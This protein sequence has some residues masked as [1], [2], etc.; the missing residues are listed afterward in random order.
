MFDTATIATIVAGAAPLLFA[1]MGETISEKAGV[2]N[3]SVDGSMMLAALAGFVAA[4]ETGSVWLGFPA[5]AAVGMLVALVVAF[6][7]IKLSLNQVAVGFVL[8]ALCTQLSRFLGSS[9]VGRLPEAVPA[10]DV[11]LLESIPFFGRVLFQQNLMVYLSILT[12]IATY[13]YMYRTRKGLELQGIGERPEAAHAR[14]IPVNR[15]R[16][17]YTALG[18]AL[19]GI[20]GAAFTLDVKLG[21][22]DRPTL[23]F[24]WIVLAIVIFGGWHPIRVAIGVLLFGALQA[25]ALN[26]IPEFPSL[27][28]VLPSIPFPLM[29]LALVIVNWKALLRW[30]DRY[31][32]LR[33]I[34][35]S[36]PPT[37]IG[38]RFEVN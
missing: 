10:W 8:F 14:G 31:P 12:V 9:Y 6:G 22:S 19:I 24:G 17:F 11:P 2:I 23:N 3:L 36:D 38:T 21:W 26:L 30:L 1:A 37:A 4:F 25:Y 29:I 15:L 34:L 28:Q 16:Y 35:R 5:A 27:S 18:G 13:V 7:S 32:W 33:A 20:G